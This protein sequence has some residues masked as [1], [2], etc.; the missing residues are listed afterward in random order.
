MVVG[1][2]RSINDRSPAAHFE[3]QQADGAV[4]WGVR[5]GDRQSILPAHHGHLV[6]V[7]LLE[8]WAPNLTLL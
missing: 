3:E 8:T 7:L 1:H 2:P 5:C 4:L 6:L